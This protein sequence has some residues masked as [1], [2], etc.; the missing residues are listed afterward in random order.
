[1]Q[2]WSV[3]A[4]GRGR[5][6][7]GGGGVTIRVSKLCLTAGAQ[8]GADNGQLEAELEVLHSG[9][10]LEGVVMELAI[11]AA[12]HN[13]NKGGTLA[14]EHVV[15]QACT[16]APDLHHR[17]AVRGIGGYG[18]GGVNG[19]GEHKFEWSSIML[20]TLVA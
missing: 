15:D 14:H 18:G 8:H 2:L 13:L 5:E 19:M 17:L 4:W 9:R 1:M 6:G 12:G 11:K 10:H 3:E 7:K 20:Y 16:M